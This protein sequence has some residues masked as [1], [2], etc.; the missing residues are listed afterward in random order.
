M[1]QKLY[2]PNGEVLPGMLVPEGMQRVALG[3][4]Y[5]GASFRGFQKQ[6]STPDTVQARLERA[7]SAVAAEE[8]TLVCAGRTDAGVSASGQV[9]HF[10]TL[11]SRPLKAWLQGVNTHLPDAVRV[12]WAMPVS[13]DFHARFSALSRTYHYWIQTEPV[14]S[15]LFSQQLTW[16]GHSLDVER[17]QLAAENLLGEH[18]FSSFR[19]AQCQAHSPVREIQA[20]SF[21][22][23]GNLILFRVRANAFLHHMVRNLIGSL[24]LVGRGL[25][26]PN[27]IE[28]LLA[29]RD[30]TLAAP[31][32]APWGLSLV[33]VEYPTAFK[34]PAAMDRAMFSQFCG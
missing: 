34:I 23:Y 2:K 26:S 4:E 3:V 16:T 17:M 29:A 25:Q 32:A 11:S 14:R 33:A 6:A 12:T 19:A 8:V 13:F 18:D 7:I 22:R 20:V 1:N 21:E 31:T 24:M 28:Q 15:A 10:D 30:R 5:L 27:W 9:I